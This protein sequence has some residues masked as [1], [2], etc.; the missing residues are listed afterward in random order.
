MEPKNV[1]IFKDV[2]IF[3]AMF[4][5]I[6]VGNSFTKISEKQITEAI[7]VCEVNEG[8]LRLSDHRI[9]CKNGAQFS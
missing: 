1:L 5:G 4:V 3:V 8:I 9:D 7:K 2:L 6:V